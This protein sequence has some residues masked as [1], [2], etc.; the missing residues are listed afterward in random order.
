M[1]EY[2]GKKFFQAIEFDADDK[3]ASFVR[4][5]VILPGHPQIDQS[6]FGFAGK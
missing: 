2:H 1:E 6:L 3:V 5:D 4:D